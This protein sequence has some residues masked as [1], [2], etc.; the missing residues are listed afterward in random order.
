MKK[1]VAYPC[2]HSCTSRAARKCLICRKR[3]DDV[4]ENQQHTQFLSDLVSNENLNDIFKCPITN[5]I[6]NEPII[7]LCGHVFEEFAIYSHFHYSSTCPV[8]RCEVDPN[9]WLTIPLEI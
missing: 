4:I 1:Y 5:E 9:D 8:C 3:V 2:G 7:L 6:I